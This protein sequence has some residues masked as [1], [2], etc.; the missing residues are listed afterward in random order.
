M[1]LN[2]LMK[3]SQGEAQG[4]DVKSVARSMVDNAAEPGE[5]QTRDEPRE[6]IRNRQRE[7]MLRQQQEVDLP[8]DDENDDSATVNGHDI[9]EGDEDDEGYEEPGQHE[10]TGD[11][12][13]EEGEEDDEEDAASGT[14]EEGEEDGEE[15][16]TDDTLIPVTVDGE[17][18]E[19]T[20]A[21]LKRRAAGEGAIE[22]RLQDA[23]E[24]RRSLE[25][26]RQEHQ[27]NIEHDRQLFTTALNLFQDRLFHPQVQQ[28]D[29]A[30]QQSDPQKYQQQYN[31]WQQ[32]QQRIQGEAQQFQAAMQQFKQQEDQALQ[33]RRAQEAQVLREKM[34][35]FK[36][37]VQGPKMRERIVTGVERYGFKPE[38]VAQAVDHRLFLMAADAVAYRELVDKQKKGKSKVQDGKKP[39]KAGEKRT[40]V[41]RGGSKPASTQRKAAKQQE[42]VNKRAWE[43]GDVKDVARTM[44][45]QPRRR[46]ARQARG[47]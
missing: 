24:L 37:K 6:P 41:M 19:L 45:V 2:D 14:D 47:N 11:E 22:R 7:Q 15:Y 36:D 8:E 46:K 20:L 31:A 16:L 10:A 26:E 25:Q 30:L 29:P 38:D 4:N 39:P 5:R 1:S 35:V 32:D 13:E 18:T 42:Q 27:Q 23:T 17:E 33:Q 3:A 28:P 34:P 9:I 40:R 44:I 12:D 21:E 43:T